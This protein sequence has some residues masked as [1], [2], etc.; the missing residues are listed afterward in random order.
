MGGIGSTFCSWNDG[1][2]VPAIVVGDGM[3][4][5]GTVV[6]VGIVAVSLAG[7]SAERVTLD[8]GTGTGW[9]CSSLS[10]KIFVS[11]WLPVSGL[12]RLLLVVVVVEDVWTLSDVGSLSRLL[13]LL[14]LLPVLLSLLRFRL[15]NPYVKPTII[16]TNNMKMTET[17]RYRCFN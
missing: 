8:V 7:G 3:V 16:I 9:S 15:V 17:L 10:S 13:L 2:L 6:G 12:S 5:D 11:L 1:A 4:G 14:M